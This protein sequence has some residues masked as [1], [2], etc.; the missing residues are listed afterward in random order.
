MITEDNMKKSGK[1]LYFNLFSFVSIVSEYR[2][3]FVRLMLLI[4][5]LIVDIIVN[6]CAYFLYFICPHVKLTI[7]VLSMQNCCLDTGRD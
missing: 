2:P 1:E 7:I 5:D 6:N 4:I 3:S